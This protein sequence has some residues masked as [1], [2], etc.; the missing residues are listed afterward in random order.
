MNPLILEIPTIAITGSSGKTTTREMIAA[1]LVQKWKLMKNTGNKNLPIHTQQIAEN[2]DATTDAILLELGMGKQGA[3]EK[4][5]SIIQPNISVITNIGTA[6]YGNLGNSIESTAQYKSALIKHMKPDGVLLINN[7]D[8]NSKLLD[9]TSFK[10]LIMTVGVNTSGDY[11]ASKIEYVPNGMTFKVSL[12]NRIEKFFIPT[13]GSHNILNALF[14]IAICHHLK[15]TIDEIRRG[16][17]QYET[18]VKRL[19]VYELRNE[20]LLIDDTV[21]ANPQS[22]KAAIDVV[23]E[24]GK[25]K[26]KLVVLG[27][28]LELGEYSM[29]GHK[30]IGQ[31]LAKHKVDAIFTYGTAAKWIREGALEAGFPAQK[32]QH[33]R[34][35]NLLHTELKHQI[36]SDSIIL[37]K[38]SSLMNMNKTVKYLQDRYLYKL[39]F[40]EN[41]KHCI[42]MNPQTYNQTGVQSSQITLNFGKLSKN[43]M[44]K[45]DENLEY[46][47]III[48]KQITNNITIPTLPY[49]YYF[50]GDQLFIGPV[51]GMMVYPRY[52]REPGL[53]LHR[54]M[55]YQQI[56]GLIFLFRPETV[57]KRKK[58]INGYYYDP[59]T[60]SFLEGTFPYPSSI[61]NRIPIRQVTYEHFKTNIGDTIFNYPYGNTNKL[62]FWLTMSRQPFVRQYLPRTTEYRNMDQL[63]ILLKSHP[64]VYL[65]PATM[66]GGN[67]ILHV[68]KNEVGYSLS[69]IQ[70]NRTEIRT[71]EAL[72]KSLKSLLIRRKKYIIQV[73]IPSFNQEQQKIDFRVYFQKDYS[74]KWKFSGVETKVG[75]RDSIISN[76]K[77]R[78]RVIPGEQALKEFYHLDE[79]QIKQKIDEM[80]SVCTKVLRLMEKTGARLGDAAVDMV[81]DHNKKLWIL[82]VQLNY[83]AEIK[84][85]RG[86]DEQRILPHILSTPFEYAK[87]LAGF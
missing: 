74:N 31:Y 10:G 22:V 12:D 1:I 76:S 9:T 85:A 60:H 6:H 17:E 23:G 66:A 78:E 46:G 70:G 11:R 62:D 72:E 4:H 73:E 34:D 16:L 3:G 68:K 13:F 37:V 2:V 7:D 54:F 45:I 81:M 67:G 35:R 79:K 21:N 49:D 25:G 47:E 77:N 29:A 42:A 59:K 44:I 53:Q 18:P 75:Q 15:F 69:D 20:S 50:I 36:Q 24:L 58:T 57:D 84:A 26:K 38:G 80:T 83:A 65:K 28:M 87:S 63:L 43:F 27:S 51:I 48:P 39:N 19:N 61:F 5:C 41:Y 56:K 14:A 33:F 64:A 40:S 30:E 71:K 52:M 86:E 82:E 32:V 8:Q 55:N